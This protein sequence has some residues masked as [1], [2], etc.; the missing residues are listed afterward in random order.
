[1]LLSESPMIWLACA[2]PPAFAT[3]ISAS[4][5]A[6]CNSNSFWSASCSAFNFNS[7]L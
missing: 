6:F 4:F 2:T 7:M 5:L 1:L 3:S